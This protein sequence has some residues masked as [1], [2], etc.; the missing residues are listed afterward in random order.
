MHA[1]YKIN[2]PKGELVL[3]EEARIKSQSS[4]RSV[5]FSNKEQ[6]NKVKA[7]EKAKYVPEIELYD[8]SARPTQK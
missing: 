4:G 5:A 1:V 2:P 8:L 3:R 6:C 7:Y